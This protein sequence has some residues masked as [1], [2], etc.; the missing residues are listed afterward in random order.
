MKHTIDLHWIP[1]QLD[2]EG[3]Y[4]IRCSTCGKV[5]IE[6]VEIKDDCQKV[7]V[8]GIYVREVIKA[9]DCLR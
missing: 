6:R 3:Y 9:K 2:G 8:L 4:Q 7:D 1:S 5:L